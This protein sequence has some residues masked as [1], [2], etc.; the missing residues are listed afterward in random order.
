MKK[1]LLILALVFASSS[2]A[3]T[4]AKIESVTI[5]GRVITDFSKFIVLRCSSNSSANNY[6][7]CTLNGSTTAY[8]VPGSTTIR[9]IGVEAKDWG[10]SDWCNGTIGYADAAAIADD[11][12]TAPTPGRIELSGRLDVATH[13]GINGAALDTTRDNA[14]TENFTIPT[15]KFPFW[16]QFLGHCSVTIYGILE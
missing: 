15:G 6:N 10:A 5:A 2:W 11:T 1:I 13:A 9:V 8:S 3:S 4:P 16:H 14:T 7:K 12:A